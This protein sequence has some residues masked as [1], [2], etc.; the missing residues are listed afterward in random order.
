MIIYQ[1]MT[2]D[3][4]NKLQEIDRSEMIDLLYEM[5]EGVLTEVKSYSECSGW[6]PDELKQI[7]ERYTFE[8]GNGGMAV[9]A[10]LSETLV[11][12]GVLSHQF[13]GE[14]KNQLAIDLMYVSRN[15]RRQGIG[16]NII[17]LLGDEARK[18]GAK[19]LYVSSTE[20]ASAVSF[21]KS[22]GGYI[23]P[24]VDEALFRK[25]PTDIHMLITL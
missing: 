22:K 3:Q 16:T 23:A 7:Q 25:E 19:Y 6:N 11:G 21:Y 13:M 5:K 9:G 20:T 15:C 14:D 4:A 2:I 8:L 1:I 10:F 18:R 24:A 12:F 17:K